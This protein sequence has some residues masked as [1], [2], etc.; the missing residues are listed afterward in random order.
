MT[1]PWWWLSFADGRKPKGS[2]FL[3]AAIV[4]GNNFLEAVRKSHKLG[5]NPG[6]QV[7]GLPIL[8]NLSIP[9]H[10]LNRLLTRSECE[11]F[12]KEMLPKIMN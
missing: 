3:G 8:N 10:W 5:C 2:Q 9:E 12:N 11:Q 6:G 7:Q 4:S 1:T